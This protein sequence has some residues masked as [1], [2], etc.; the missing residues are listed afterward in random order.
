MKKV[1]WLIIG[2]LIL[3]LG[4]TGCKETAVPVDG[5]K[6]QD[7]EQVQDNPDYTDEDQETED[8]D[9]EDEVVDEEPTETTDP[10]QEEIIT[11]TQWE[12]TIEDTIMLEGMDE[13]IT[14]N[15]FQ[16]KD[17]ITYVPDNLIAEKVSDNLYYFYANF[18]GIKRED[19]YMRLNFFPDSKTTQPDLTTE[20]ELFTELNLTLEPI[21]ADMVPYDWSLSEYT[22]MDGAWY[23]IGEHN[24]SYF[25]MLFSYP[26]EFAEGFMPR[27]EKVIDYLYWTDTNAYL[28]EK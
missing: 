7:E 28:V 25:S 13:P 26:L 17:F 16:S 21:S 22:N 19:V 9:A 20:K 24:G 6:N 3:V 23:V 27:V 18:A 1:T 14:L 11:T 12:G 2:L 4:M 15:L 5:S 8:N 10:T